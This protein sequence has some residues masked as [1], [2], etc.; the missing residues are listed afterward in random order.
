MRVKYILILH[1]ARL[2]E[3]LTLI[4]LQEVTAGAV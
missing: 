2:V 4:T 3:R 1:D